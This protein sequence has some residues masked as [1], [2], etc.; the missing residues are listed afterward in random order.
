[1]K[2]LFGPRH[3][4]PLFAL[5]LSFTSWTCRSS[6]SSSTS[7][8]TIAMS[9]SPDT[10]QDFSPATPILPSAELLAF[11]ESQAPEQG[12]LIPVVVEKGADVL[13]PWQV[14]IGL[15]EDIPQADRLYLNLDDTAL[16]IPLS[17][18]FRDYLGEKEYAYAWLHCKKGSLMPMG[19]PGSAEEQARTFTVYK[20]AERAKVRA[21]DGYIFV[22]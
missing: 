9:S 4:I 1:M 22:R 10:P 11:F 17:D 6:Q 14:F 15:R 2:A 8:S 3:L 16:G 12:F 18:H 13:R 7:D 21:E 19:L 5:F 20:V